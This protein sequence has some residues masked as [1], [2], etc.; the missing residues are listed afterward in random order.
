M[1]PRPSRIREKARHSKNH[2]TTESPSATASARVDRSA[3]PLWTNSRT[4]STRRAGRSRRAWRP[5]AGV[6]RATTAATRRRAMPPRRSGP[7]GS[8]VTPSPPSSDEPGHVGQAL[9]HH[10]GRREAHRR[11]DEVA[12]QDG[13]QHLA[14]LARRDRHR[15]PGEKDPEARLPGERDL[16][17]AEVE[18]PLREAQSPSSRRPPGGRGGRASSGTVASASSVAGRFAVAASA[19]RHGGAERDRDQQ[20]TEAG[21]AATQGR[22][23]APDPVTVNRARAPG[24][25]LRRSPPGAAP[26]PSPAPAGPPATARGRRP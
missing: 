10:D 21:G 14:E 26:A 16:E 8:A 25:R 12:D 13:L 17:A 5:T 22:I 11:A 3:R 24:R 9:R 2:E 6:L 23:R 18:V 15:E 20:A 1:T 7:R 4:G 19:E